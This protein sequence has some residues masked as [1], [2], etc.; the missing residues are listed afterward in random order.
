MV[1]TLEMTVPL[2]NKELTDST[3]LGATPEDPVLPASLDRLVLTANL[4]LQ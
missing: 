4:E 3:A 1:E 2:V